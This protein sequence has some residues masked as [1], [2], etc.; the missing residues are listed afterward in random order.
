MKIE[1]GKQYRFDYPNEFTTLPEYTAH[2]GQIVTVLHEI[3]VDEE[4]QPMFRVQ[5]ADG[6]QGDAIQDELVEVGS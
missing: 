6:W 3:K 1:I 2:K 5:A 4:I